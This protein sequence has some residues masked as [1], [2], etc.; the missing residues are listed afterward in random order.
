VG[1][2]LKALSSLTVRGKKTI[3]RSVPSYLYT[4]SFIVC[5]YALNN[6]LILFYIFFYIALLLTN[7]LFMIGLDCDY[8]LVF[9]ILFVLHD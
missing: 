6:L 4:L 9:C 7:Q 8:F 3:A 1:S 2:G 5:L